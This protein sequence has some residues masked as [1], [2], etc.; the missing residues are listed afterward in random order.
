MSWALDG[1]RLR[2]ARPAVLQPNPEAGRV[3]APHQCNGRAHPRAARRRARALFAVHR[4]PSSARWNSVLQN[5]T[6]IRLE[7]TAA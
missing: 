6:A 7:R 4:R 1:M 5:T 2:L 3:I